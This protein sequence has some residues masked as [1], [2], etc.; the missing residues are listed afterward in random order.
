MSSKIYIKLNYK[1]IKRFI[2]KSKTVKLLVKFKK[3][4]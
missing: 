1:I 4:V 3:Y 2:K